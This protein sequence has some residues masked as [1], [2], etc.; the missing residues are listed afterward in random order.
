MQRLEAIFGIRFGGSLVVE[1]MLGFFN[2]TKCLRFSAQKI[3]EDVQKIIGI[4]EI[5]FQ[6]K[7]TQADMDPHGK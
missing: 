1:A 2:N 4:L 3:P 7:N 5:N 6:T